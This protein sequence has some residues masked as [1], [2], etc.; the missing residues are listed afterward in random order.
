MY[1]AR[2]TFERALTDTVLSTWGH[3]YVGLADYR[4]ANVLLAQDKKREADASERLKKA[5]EHL[6]IAKR[7]V[8]DREETNE[9]AAEVCALLS[10]VYGRQISLSPIK[11]IYLGPKAKSVLGKAEQ[12]APGNPRVVLS[13]AIS[14]LM[15]PRLV[16][17]NKTKA[18]AGFRRAA[19]LFA[20][21]TPADPIHP[22]WGHSDTYI[23]MGIAYMERKESGSRPGGF[24]K[25][26]LEIDPDNRWVREKLSK[27]LTR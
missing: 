1:A 26:A 10:N 19:K 12:L 2:S 11:G 27:D 8:D 13:S 15:T 17:G 7:A 9:T 16:G 20:R 6:Q 21:E 23:W 4:I 22:V 25:K 24:R 18:M 14:Y 3:Y 5:V